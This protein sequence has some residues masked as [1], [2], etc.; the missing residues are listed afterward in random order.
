MGTIDTNAQLKDVPRNYGGRH[1]EPPY[2]TEQEAEAETAAKPRQDVQAGE[3]D[4]REFNGMV[5]IRGLRSY[6]GPSAS[7]ETNGL[8]HLHRFTKEQLLALAEV[9][10]YAAARAKDLPDQ[11]GGE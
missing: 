1:Y 10:T 3:L 9:A 4:I 8:V 6:S 2:P 7:L 5:V 11:A